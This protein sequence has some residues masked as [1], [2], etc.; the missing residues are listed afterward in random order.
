M[1]KEEFE[2]ALDRCCE[3]LTLEARERGFR[4]SNDFEARVR[5]TLAEL[6]KD[7]P[8]LKIDFNS[9]AQAFPDIAMGAY[10]VEVKYTTANMWRSVANSIQETQ[11]VQGVMSV[12]IVFG[13]MGGIPEVR[14][15]E[16]EESVIHVRTSHVPRFEV[17]IATDKT[18]AKPSLFK[19]MGIRYDDFR[20]L[21]MSEKI[22][23]IR[24]YA[25][26]IHPDGRLWWLEK[27]DALAVGWKPSEV[28]FRA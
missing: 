9:P 3:I 27:A 26:Q 2:G 25:R 8:E 13:K 22:K 10:G 28:L 15:G 6:T 20:R 17:E 5:E 14:W 16:Y 24:K 1:T 21:D 7:D 18:R 4:S 19:R 12:Y 23:Y 11:R